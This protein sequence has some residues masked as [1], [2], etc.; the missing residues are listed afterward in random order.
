MNVAAQRIQ[1]TNL[2]STGQQLT[3]NVLTDEAG[4]TGDENSHARLPVAFGCR[5]S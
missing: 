2:M 5:R 3:H 4:A 1:Q